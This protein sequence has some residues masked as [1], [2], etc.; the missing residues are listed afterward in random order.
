MFPLMSH[1]IVPLQLR[2]PAGCGGPIGGL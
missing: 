1:V 2:G